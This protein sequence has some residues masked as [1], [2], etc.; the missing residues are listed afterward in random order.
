MSEISVDVSNSKRN[1]YDTQIQHQATQTPALW[2]MSPN[3]KYKSTNTKT[4][5]DW[6]FESCNSLWKWVG[7]PF[8]ASIDTVSFKS[9]GTFMVSVSGSISASVNEP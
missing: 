2:E 6:D 3:V 5:L 9:I 7:N 1:S 8:L 4:D